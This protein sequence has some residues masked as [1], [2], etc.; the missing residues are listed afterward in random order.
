[1][2]FPIL[3]MQQP[4]SGMWGNA[5]IVLLAAEE[6]KSFDVP[7]GRH[8]VCYVPRVDIPTSHRKVDPCPRS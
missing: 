8:A 4:G 5:T 7:T 2:V 6:A 3:E 1:M